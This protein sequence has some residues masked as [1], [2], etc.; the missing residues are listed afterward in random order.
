MIFRSGYLR[1]TIGGLLAV[2][3]ACYL[4]NSFAHFL[5]PALG[6][7]L[8]NA[9]ILVPCLIAE[10][11]LAVRLIV[12]GVDAAKWDERTGALAS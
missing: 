9:G 4:V 5:D 8:F 6:A 10:L 3:G 12:K 7:K 1:R 11:S 2:A